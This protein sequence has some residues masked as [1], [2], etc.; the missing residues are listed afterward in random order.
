MTYTMSQRVRKAAL[1]THITVSVG[2]IGAVATYLALAVTGL[3]SQDGQLVRAAYLAMEVTAFYVIVP[4]A[5]ATLL[6]GLVMA[7]GTRWG[8]FRHY[9][10]LISLL[11]TIIA[12]VILL[13][14]LENI[15]YAAS[16]AADPTTS[17][18]DLRGAAG[19][20]LHS[21][22]GLV[23]LLVITALNV[24]KPQGLTP[25]GWRKIR[26]QRTESQPSSGSN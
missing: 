24:Y 5:V 11:L 3:T 2:W 17:S 13:T 7:L 18:A 16:I 9:W 20:V 4:L 22:L 6:T 19:Q 21:G 26:K 12:I 14:Q 25:Y 8:L 23:V 15:R 10:V 1:T